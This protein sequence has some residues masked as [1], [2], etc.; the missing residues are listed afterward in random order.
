[1]NDKGFAAEVSTRAAVIAAAIM[2]VWLA[3]PA[4]AQSC[5][6]MPPGPAKKQCVMQSHP[7]AFEKKKERCLQLAEERGSAGKAS[8]QKNFMQSCM[9]AKSGSSAQATRRPVS[10]IATSRTLV[11]ISA[12]RIAISTSTAIAS[13]VNIVIPID[14]W[15]C[16]HSVR[17]ARFSRFSFGAKN[18]FSR[19]SRLMVR[20]GRRRVPCAR[21][22]PKI[23]CNRLV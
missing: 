4:E 14:L 8:G 10:E 16:R 3:R 12:T 9:R 21:P 6:D 13:T 20:C 1:M 7:E 11:A 17:V 22:M 19:A 18:G 2:L 15:T 23:C 5:K